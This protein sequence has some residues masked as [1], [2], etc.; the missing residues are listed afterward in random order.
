[1]PGEGGKGK[2][3]KTGPKKGEGR[4]APKLVAGRTTKELRK[5]LAQQK[6]KRERVR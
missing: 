6:E 1:M 2:E 4:P 3:T 5:K